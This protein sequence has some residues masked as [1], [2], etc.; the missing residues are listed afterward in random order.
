VSGFLGLTGINRVCHAVE[1][2]LDEGRKGNL[3]I[4]GRIADLVLEIVDFLKMM[5][6]LV[7]E[8]AQPQMALQQYESQVEAALERIVTVRE[9][10][11]TETSAESMAARPL[12][13]I[14]THMEVVSPASL[15]QAIEIQRNQGG[16][17]GEI[18]I[19]EQAVKPI[20]VAHALRDQH[21]ARESQGQRDKAPAESAAGASAGMDSIRVRINLLDQLMNLAGELVLGRNQLLQ[22]M[23]ARSDEVQGLNSILHDLDRV[24]SEVQE[25]VMQTR[26]QPMGSLFSRFHRVVRDLARGMGKQIDLHIEGEAVELDKTLIEALTDPLTHLVRNCCDHG[27]E[28]PE[29]RRAAGK[30][31]KGLVSLVAEHA[32]GK[33]HVTVKDDGA[34]VN[35]DRV[36]EKAIENGIVTREHAASMSER[37][38]LRL[39]FQPGFSTA[40]VVTDVSGRGV[41]MDVVISNI[42][43]IGGTVEVTS[44]R[45]RGTTF[46]LD[47]PLTLAIVPALI[48]SSA[49]QRFAMPQTNILELVHLEPDDVSRSVREVRGSEVL[50]LRGEMLP[51]IR[52]D[53][54][55]N[56]NRPEAEPDA[57]QG[58]VSIAVVASGIHQFGLVVDRVFDTEE[59]VVKPLSSLLKD[60]GVFDGATLMG[61]GQAAL[62]LDVAGLMRA[63]ELSIDE[64]AAGDR[65]GL[66]REESEGEGEDLQTLLL[67]NINPEERLAVPLNLISRLETVRMQDIR[68]S[69]QGKVM[70]YRNRL[71]PLI[72]LEEHTRIAPAP[73]ARDLVKV[74]VFEI[75]HPVGLVV[76]DI[77]DSTQTV[78]QMDDAGI[79]QPGFTGIAMVDGEATAFIDIYEVIELA[80]PDW[81]KRGKRGRREPDNK[82]GF[83]LLLA[84]D[85]SFY[86]NVERNY[87][88]QEGFHV[89]EAADGQQA[90]EMLQRESVDLLVTDIEMPHM[91]GFELAAAVRQSPQLGGLPIIAVTSLSDDAERE[92]GM[93][94][95][96]NAYLI[97]L[98]REQLLKEVNRLLLT[99]R[100]AS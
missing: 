87:L 71:L 62:I 78:V 68:N 91:N 76:T 13:E 35:I 69:I 39:L 99:Q 37:E 57:P 34:G 14:L 47:L 92:K 56:L 83:T 60:V 72:F 40:Q 85:S 21:K 32:G 96:I 36:K 22:K 23:S 59:I 26:M 93:R 58:P 55:L 46:L 31:D 25:A 3:E 90:L 42:E 18:L 30:P 5:I 50:E 19:R 98:Q 2:L 41:G 9:S 29:K 94:V 17:L 48:V 81:F 1:S 65:F 73:H 44:E 86:R 53:R 6:P 45:G 82:T 89:L 100:K 80:F 8:S 11:G 28:T 51:L 54:V 15:E 49:D 95:G 61:D 20:A 67:F 97:K 12:G 75:E 38:A 4:T 24:T 52:L 43:R 63:A 79:T 66:K 70:P 64:E 10:A 27:V 7:R 88:M 74:L 33:V 84:E 77:V 16:N